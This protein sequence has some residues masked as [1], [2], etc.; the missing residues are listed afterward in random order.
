MVIDFGTNRKRVHVFILVV[1]IYLDHP[2]LHRFRDTAA[3]ISKIDNFPCPT[4]IPA[5]ILGVSF[6]VDPSCRGLQR[7]K[8]LG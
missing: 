3:Y 7:V 4:P 5:K 2:I 6:G 8:R 1:N